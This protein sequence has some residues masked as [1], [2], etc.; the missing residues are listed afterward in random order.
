MKKDNSN[1]ATNVFYLFLSSILSGSIFVC[2]PV[3]GIT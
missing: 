2:K 3:T 1:V